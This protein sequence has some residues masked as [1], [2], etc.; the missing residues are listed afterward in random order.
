LEQTLSEFMHEHNMADVMED[1]RDL[2][3][4]I[5]KYHQLALPVIEGAKKLKAVIA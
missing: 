1:Q 5:A 4:K 2:A 3:Q